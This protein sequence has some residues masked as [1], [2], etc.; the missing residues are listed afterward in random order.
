MTCSEADENCP[1]VACAV[2][3]IAVPYDDPKSADGTN[4]EAS[5]YDKRCAQISREMLYVFS[6]L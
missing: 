4:A 3:R 1:T 6:Q 2:A 5:I